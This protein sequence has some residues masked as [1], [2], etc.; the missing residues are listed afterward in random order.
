[1]SWPG[2]GGDKCWRRVSCQALYSKVCKK[3]CFASRLSCIKLSITH[4]FWLCTLWGPSKAQES[5]EYLIGVYFSVSYPEITCTVWYG[6]LPPCSGGGLFTKSCPTH[7]PMD[8]R[9]SGS[10]IHGILQARIL[11]WVAISLSSMQWYPQNTRADKLSQRSGKESQHTLRSQGERKKHT[12]DRLQLAWKDLRLWSGSIHTSYLSL[13]PP[14]DCGVVRTRGELWA[15]VRKWKVLL[16]QGTVHQRDARA[17]EAEHSPSSRL[18]CWALRGQAMHDTERH[19]WVA[20]LRPVCAACLADT[21]RAVNIW[22]SYMFDAS[23]MFSASWICHIASS[24][25]LFQSQFSS[26]GPTNLSTVPCSW[27]TC[28]ICA[29]SMS[30]VCPIYFFS[31]RQ[32]WIFSDNTVLGFR[33]R[34]VPLWW[35]ECPQHSPTSQDSFIARIMIECMKPWLYLSTCIHACSVTQSCLTLRSHGLQPTMRLCPWDFPGKSTGVLFA[36]SSS[37]G[38]SQPRDRI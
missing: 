28:V 24:F 25:Q 30:L 9:P 33:A 29:L 35:W 18:T 11:E 19:R 26:L 2:E 20:G 27:I 8:C 4:G 6:R 12:Q 31:S 23:C 32:N 13:W 7:N 15:R 16:A 22:C 3:G 37:R 34:M 5:N 36:I 1:M 14:L 17:R 38:S 10:S 21:Q